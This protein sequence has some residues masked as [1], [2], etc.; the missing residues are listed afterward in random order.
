MSTK[1]RTGNQN[2]A[3]HVYFELLAKALNDAGY[4]MRKV[5]KQDVEIPW[6]KASVKN[7]L[8]RPIQDVM[9]DKESTTEL[10]TVE[11]SEIYEVLNKHIAEKFGISIPW[12]SYYE[13]S[14][15]R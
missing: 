8:W 6:T 1:K 2:R 11:P 10:N 14:L 15:G 5:L 4:D 7:H 12:P 13:Q 3:V 9:L